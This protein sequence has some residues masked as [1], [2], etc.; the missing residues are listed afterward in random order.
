[1]NSQAVREALAAKEDRAD[2]VVLAEMAEMRTP[3]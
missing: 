2:R 1:M 3:M